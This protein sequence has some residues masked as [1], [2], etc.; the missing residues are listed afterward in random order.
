MSKLATFVVALGALVLAFVTL[1]P[2]SAE[3]G[4]RG[5]GWGWG[6]PGVNVYVG[7]RYGY[8]GGPG[9]YRPYRYSY[10]YGYPYG[11]Y[12]YWRRGYYRGWY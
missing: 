5:R 3:A 7:P 4:W 11:Y 2:N 6:G 8:Y 9:Y 10:G 1:S 12:P